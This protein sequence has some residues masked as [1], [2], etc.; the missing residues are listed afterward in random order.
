MYF[1]NLGL[2]SPWGDEAYSFQTMRLPVPEIL[3]LLAHDVHPPLY[4]L[5][6]YGWLRVPLGLS[7]EVQARALSGICVLA[8][9]VAADRWWARRLGERGRL[10]F[11]AIWAA[12]PCL[13]LYARIC[14]S[15][16]LQLLLGTVVAGL[17]LR[18]AEGRSWRNGVWLAAGLT[19]ALY[20]HYVPGIALAA[21]ANLWL[22]SKKRLRDAVILDTAVGV[23]Y[24]PWLWWLLRALGE[25]GSRPPSYFFT[26][27]ALTETPIKLAYWAMSF[28]LGEAQPDWAMVAGAGLMALVG[29]LAVMG[30]RRNRQVAWLAAVLA[31]IGFI[32]VARWVSYPFIPARLLFVY[33]LLLVLF[34]EG[35][36]AHRRAGAVAVAGLLILAVTGIWSYSHQAG[37]RN[38]QYVMPI[39]EIAAEIDRQS[40]ENSVVL[41]DTPNSDFVALRYCLGPGR[42]VLE[43]REATAGPAM[44]AAI[45]DPTVR[46]I[47]FLRSPHDVTP[48]QLDQRFEAQLRAAMAAKAEWFGPFSPLERRA[49]GALGMERPP[50][51]FQELL[52]FER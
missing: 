37:Y 15:F 17:V 39:R 12:S 31:A 2:L 41:V 9:T 14:H 20:T 35:A 42:R 26:G 10:C 36:M 45:A 4:Y 13:V 48:E 16:C 23:A 5:L 51:Y 28:V 50:Q 6:L 34:V 46:T 25:W 29:V 27:G 38:Q 21:A 47:W 49:L 33:P 3:R 24:L 44:E 22:L 8:A 7:W 43:T 11:L 30:A 40:A 52:K 32:G 1:W 18:F 19:A